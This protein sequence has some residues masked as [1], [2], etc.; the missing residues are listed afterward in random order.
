MRGDRLRILD[1]IEQIELIG[2]FAQPD[3]DNPFLRAAIS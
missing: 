2:T 1:A 3:R